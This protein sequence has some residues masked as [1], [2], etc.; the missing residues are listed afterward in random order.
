MTESITGPITGTIALDPDQ[1]RVVGHGPGALEVLGGPGTGK[2][3]VL[4]ERF[5]S[6]TRMGVA[7]DRILFLVPN[8]GQKMALQD[9]LTRRLLSDEG[10]E[11][12][13]EVPVYTWHGLAYH[14][15]SRHY[16]KLDYSEPPVLLT[17]PEQWGAIRQALGKESKAN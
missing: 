10:L 16:D 5:I 1:Q 15:V 2:T 3:R 14:L 8:R 12:L 4:E 17:S 13:I 6:L 11:A 9:R 7:P